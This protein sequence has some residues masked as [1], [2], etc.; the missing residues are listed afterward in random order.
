MKRS[1]FVS[2]LSLVVLG[3]TMSGQQA[4]ASR[5]TAELRG[6]ASGH[7][8]ESGDRARRGLRG[9]SEEPERL[10]RRHRGRRRVEKREPRQRLDVDLRQRRVV[11]HVL[12]PDRSEGH[13][14]SVGRHGRELEPAQLD[15]WRRRLQVHRRRQD[16]DARRAQ[17]LRA[18]RQHADGS[19]QLRTSST[20]RRK[21]RSGR[22]AAIAAST[23]RPTAARRGGRS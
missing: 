14:R 9:R 19:A 10:L 23:R 16:V 1:W 22:P 2:L 4:P 17:E 7:R 5:L 18:H 13:Q 3:V 11:Q 6:L 12:H 8:A 20:S 15:D 21:G